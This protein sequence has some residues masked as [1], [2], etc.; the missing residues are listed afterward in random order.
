[1]LKAYADVSGGRLTSDGDWLEVD[2][3][4]QVAEVCTSV[5]LSHKELA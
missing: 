1:M 2:M 3:V 5:C 4:E